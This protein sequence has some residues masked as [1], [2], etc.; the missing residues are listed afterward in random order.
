MIGVLGLNSWQGLGIFLF[1]TA[2]RTA[3][4]S[5]QPSI[6]WVPGA[7]SLGV[8]WLGHEAGYSPPSSAEVKECLDLY[9]HSPSMP[10]WCGDQLKKAWGQLKLTFSLLLFRKPSFLKIVTPDFWACKKYVSD[11]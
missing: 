7:L 5:T 8:K 11:M 2:F 9:F 3:L 6:Q 10:L 4:G 1:T